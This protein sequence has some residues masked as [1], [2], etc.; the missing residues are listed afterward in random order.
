MK[1]PAIILI[2]HKAP[3]GKAMAAALKERFGDGFVGVLAIDRKKSR[4][5]Q[6]RRRIKKA[7]TTTALERRVLRVERKLAREAESVFLQRAKPPETWPQGIAVHYTDNP[8]NAASIAWLADHA[9]DIIA[10]TGAPILRQP[11]FDLAPMGALN[12]HSSIL[13]DYR[14]TQAEF[15]QVLEGRVDTCGVTIHYI[16]AGVD[17]GQIVLQRPTQADPTT[18]PQM[19]RTRN[20]ITALDAMPDALE[21]VF[22]GSADPRQQGQGGT[23]RRSQDKT[24]A[25]RARLL[26]GLGYRAMNT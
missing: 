24:L 12:M 11:V 20:L 25:L 2:C 7:L 19:V 9:P 5:K 18:S 14:G 26:A 8:N 21:S 17:T 22:D 6:L 15:W 4:L 23:A 13:P 10:V 16:D 3:F 1:Q